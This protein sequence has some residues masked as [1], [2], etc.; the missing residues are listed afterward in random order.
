MCKESYYV[1]A[2]SNSTT[3]RWRRKLGKCRYPGSPNTACLRV[4]LRCRFYRG[5]EERAFL[6]SQFGA[7]KQSCFHR[8]MRN[9]HLGNSIAQSCFP[10]NIDALHEYRGLLDQVSRLTH[11]HAS[12]AV[13]PQFAFDEALAFL[14]RCDLKDIGDGLAILHRTLVTK[15]VIRG[16]KRNR[17][18]GNCRGPN[19]GGEIANDHLL[20]DG[21]ISRDFEHLIFRL[22]KRQQTTDGAQPPMLLKLR[23]RSLDLDG[24]QTPGARLF[25]CGDTCV[26]G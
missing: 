7:S 21:R 5:L 24:F 1:L 12:V 9:P 15:V 3:L 6:D 13:K 22:A 25:Q 16:S 18:R 26:R 19:L 4:R 8:Q 14:A 2:G 10:S 17:A 11:N 20:S 23:Q